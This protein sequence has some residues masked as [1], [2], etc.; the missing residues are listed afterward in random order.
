MGDERFDYVLLR[1][2]TPTIPIVSGMEILKLTH[3][4][5]FISDHFGLCTVF[6]TTV[7]LLP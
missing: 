5:R 1:A 7:V 6:E 2:G 3:N 4:G